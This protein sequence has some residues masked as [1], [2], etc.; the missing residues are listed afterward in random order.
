MDDR[1]LIR[2]FEGVHD[3]RFLAFTG[4]ALLAVAIVLG[5]VALGFRQN[6]VAKSA[7]AMVL[8][9]SAPSQTPMPPPAFPT[10]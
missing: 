3:K 2:S 6:H 1:A 8:V 5:G 4:L 10:K 7:D 9:P